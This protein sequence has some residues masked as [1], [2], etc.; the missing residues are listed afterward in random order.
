MQLIR[1]LL[2]NKGYDNF[3]KIRNILFKPQKTVVKLEKDEIFITYAVQPHVYNPKNTK[4][5]GRVVPT[6]II[7]RLVD[8]NKFL[9]FAAHQ[10]YYDEV[11]DVRKI[12]LET[13]V[14]NK[15]IELD[16]FKKL[17]KEASFLAY[18]NNEGIIYLIGLK[19]NGKHLDKHPQVIINRFF[20]GWGKSGR[21]STGNIIKGAVEA[22]DDISFCIWSY[23]IKDRKSQWIDETFRYKPD[24][25]IMVVDLNDVTSIF[26]YAEISNKEKVMIIQDLLQKSYLIRK[27]SKR[28]YKFSV[29]S[30]IGNRFTIDYNNYFDLFNKKGIMKNFDKLL[31]NLDIFRN[32]EKNFSEISK[33]KKTEIL[34]KIG[35]NF[36]NLARSDLFNE[37]FIYEGLNPKLRGKKISKEIWNI[38]FKF[39]IK[40]LVCLYKK[41]IGDR[42]DT[43]IKTYKR[44]KNDPLWH[45]HPAYKPAI[46]NFANM[47]VR[48]VR[49]NGDNAV[50]NIRRLKPNSDY[51]FVRILWKQAKNCFNEY[52]K[53]NKKEFWELD[54]KG[55]IIKPINLVDPRVRYREYKPFDLEDVKI[56][57]ELLGRGSSKH[58]SENALTMVGYYLISKLEYTSYKGT[59]RE[60]YVVGKGRL[61]NVSG[62]NEWQ[63]MRRIDLVISDDERNLNVLIEAK[64]LFFDYKINRNFNEIVASGDGSYFIKDSTATI[65]DLAR[66]MAAQLADGRGEF[67][68]HIPEIETLNDEKKRLVLNIII[69][70]FR[71]K[72]SEIAN[73]SSFNTN[74]IKLMD[75]LKPRLNPRI[76]ELTKLSSGVKKIINAITEKRDQAQVVVFLLYDIFS[77]NR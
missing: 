3:N 12:A 22:N 63:S 66:V 21:K 45:I 76:D 28:V 43:I 18:K 50:F 5:S 73:K 10:T 40:N 30:V 17:G 15:G 19:H 16:N 37:L 11:P 47:M 13:L 54:K 51:A 25:K 32:N 55:G 20:D 61:A 70:E 35:S 46:E 48:I 36:A 7:Y 14:V 53:D 56:I 31:V 72:M 77:C 71:G 69:L 49:V 4:I 9:F 29:K 27:S 44:A 33:K 8:N 64:K 2:E 75:I 60:E 38:L 57:R 65:K 24:F 42:A 74:W 62:I 59:I 67:W 68:I 58:I 39:H 41:E 52:I 34:E 26:Q 23:I 1:E 6:Q